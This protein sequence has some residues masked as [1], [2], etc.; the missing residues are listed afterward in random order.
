MDGNRYYLNGQ[1]SIAQWQCD[2][3]V[4]MHWM[5]AFFDTAAIDTDM[6][7]RNAGLRDSAAF[8]QAQKKQ[9]T[10]DT[11]C[12]RLSKVAAYNFSPFNAANCSA[13]DDGGD[14]GFDGCEFR[15]GLFLERSLSLPR[16]FAPSLRAGF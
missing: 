3:V 2:N 15:S 10:V 9:Q 6:P 7:R 8:G 4:H 11:R 5:A 1:Y 12:I 16:G 14:A 13:S